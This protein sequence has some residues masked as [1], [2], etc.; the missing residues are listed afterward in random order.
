[1]GSEEGAKCGAVSRRGGVVGVVAACTGG[2]DS[3]IRS[4][5]RRKKTTDRL[6]GRAHLLVRR[7]RR[8]RLGRKEGGTEVGHG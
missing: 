7:R 6:I 4:G 3:G 2:G 1:V 5:F 8:G